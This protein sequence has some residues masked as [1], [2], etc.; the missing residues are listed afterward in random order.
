LVGFGQDLYLKIVP[1]VSG[2]VIV[3]VTDEQV[4]AWGGIAKGNG[5]NACF[6]IAGFVLRVGSEVVEAIGS[7][8]QRADIAV[9]KTLVQLMQGR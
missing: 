6:D 4:A 3:D 1:Q 2:F 8:Y 5:I 7:Q 9:Y